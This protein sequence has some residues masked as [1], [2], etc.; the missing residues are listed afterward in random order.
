M[1]IIYMGTPDFA[2]PSLE[3]IYNAGHEILLV[4]SQ[5]DKPKGRGKKVLYTPV[6]EKALELSLEV[7]QPENINDVESID[8]IRGLNPDFIVVAAYGQILKKELLS[9][10]K[11][12]CLNVH[13]SLLPKYRGAAPINWAI[14]NGEKHTGISIMKMEEGL[15]TGDVVMLSSFEISEQDDYMSIHDKL[16]ELGGEMVVEAIDL[17]SSGKASYTPQ[18]HES[19]T[20]A[21][22]IFKNT[23]I[24]HWNKSGI[25]IINLI[26]GLKPWPSAYTYYKGEM[27]KI[28]NAIFTNEKS[29]GEMGEIIKVDKEGI[30][31]N[32]EDGMVIVKELQFSG[33]KKLTVKEYLAGNSIEKGIILDKE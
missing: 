15:D 27:V 2:V 17:I 22:M 9:I 23:G 24:I 12:G 32:V 7:Y 13:A 30:Y 33:K 10:P 28:H 5:K 1:R 14:I 8:K 18:D 25:D 31:V 20:Y 3:S 6:K 26:R 16:A 4:I 29:S 11:Y 21:S 19:S